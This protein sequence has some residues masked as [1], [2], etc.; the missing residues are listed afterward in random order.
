MPRRDGNAATK[1]E[2]LPGAQNISGYLDSLAWFKEKVYDALNIPKSRLQSDNGF[3]LGKSQE[4]SRDEVKFQKFIDR[5][6][7]RFGQILTDA[8]RTQLILTGIMSLDDWEEI[9]SDVRLDFQK[10]NYFSE[11]KNQEIIQS[12]FTLLQ[13][14]DPYLGKYISKE[15]VQREILNQTEEEIKDMDKEIKSELDDPTA[16]PEWQIQGQVQQDMQMAAQSQMQP[17]TAPD[18]SDEQNQQ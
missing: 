8:L 4:I 5:L 14:I 15:W 12:R 13:M 7:N 18:A 10:D 9:R 11:L 3:S 6:R 16:K 17:Q 1:I 2:S